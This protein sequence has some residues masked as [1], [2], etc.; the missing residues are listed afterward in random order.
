MCYF[1][2]HALMTTLGSLIKFLL[3]LPTQDL[4][5]CCNLKAH[6]GI[7]FYFRPGQPLSPNARSPVNDRGEGAPGV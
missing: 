1:S 4:G 5:S 2:P 6:L 3:L 7:F